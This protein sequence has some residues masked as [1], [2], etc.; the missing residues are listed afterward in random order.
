MHEFVR[1]NHEAAKS[2]SDYGVNRGTGSRGRLTR[3]VIKGI[4]VVPDVPGEFRRQAEVVQADI[5]T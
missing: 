1:V 5:T 4:C 3:Q 2:V